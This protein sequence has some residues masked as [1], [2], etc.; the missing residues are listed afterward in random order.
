MWK[1]WRSSTRGFQCFVISAAS[2]CN[3]W[4][5]CS[6][7]NMCVRSAW[8]LWVSTRT[9]ISGRVWLEIF[10]TF[11]RPLAVRRFTSTPNFKVNT[12]NNFSNGWGTASRKTRLRSRLGTRTSE[13]LSVHWAWPIQELRTVGGIPSR[14]LYR[15]WLMS[16]SVIIMANGLKLY[17]IFAMP[18]TMNRVLAIT[19]L[20]STMISLWRLF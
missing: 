19:K 17:V 18:L 2:S 6:Q 20:E 3:F 12:L 15:R 8:V 14:K 1:T 5:V 4:D 16:A 13:K 9:S 7:V 10:L 11:T